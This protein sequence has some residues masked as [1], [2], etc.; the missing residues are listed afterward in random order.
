MSTTLVSTGSTA[1]T[2]NGGLLIRPQQLNRS[3]E[4]AESRSQT[5]LEEEQSMLLQSHGF[6]DS[7][8]GWSGYRST[9]APRSSDRAGATALEKDNN[10]LRRKMV[11]MREESAALVRQNQDLLSNLEKLTWE[12]SK[13]QNRV[14]DREG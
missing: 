2:S 11:A 8:A 7:P 13:A 9:P 3:A 5:A 1:L 14:S 10:H 6:E 4:E 12:F